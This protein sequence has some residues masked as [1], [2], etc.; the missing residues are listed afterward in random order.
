[1]KVEFLDIKW[2]LRTVCHSRC[3]TV[4]CESLSSV[5]DGM[6]VSQMVMMMRWLLC[7]SAYSKSMSHTIFH[8]VPTTT[9]KQ[10]WKKGFINHF[11]RLLILAKFPADFWISAFMFC[12]VSHYS[13]NQIFVQKFNIDKTSNIFTKFS[14]KVF[15]TMFLR[16]QSWIF[17][18]KMKIS[19]IL[20]NKS[21]S[22]Q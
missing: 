12:N 21:R 9:N 3:I 10:K 14:P 6:R 1:M 16:N 22:F 8:N 19:N 7:F 18:Q 2:R 15:L 5:S 13:K 20:L 4:T 11:L 17:G